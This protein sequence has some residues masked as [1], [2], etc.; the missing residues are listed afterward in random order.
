M[1]HIKKLSPHSPKYVIPYNQQRSKRYGLIMLNSY[2]RP[3]AAKE[4]SYFEQLLK[5]AEFNVFKI[6]WSHSKDLHEELEKALTHLTA[7][8]SLLLVCLM[9]HGSR[10]ELAGSTGAPIPINNVLKHLTKRLSM[11]LPVVTFM[12]S[13]V[14]LLSMCYY[15]IVHLSSFIGVIT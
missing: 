15:L 14:V 5:I 9:A 3:N 12:S 2:K 8:C 6:Q 13:F 11:T 7:D 10:G 1:E 4:A